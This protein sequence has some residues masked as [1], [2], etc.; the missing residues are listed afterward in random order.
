MKTASYYMSLPYK[1]VVLNFTNPL[2]LVLQ[3]RLGGSVG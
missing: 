3:G 1:I 2:E